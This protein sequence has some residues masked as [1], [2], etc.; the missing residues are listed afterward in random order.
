MLRK[1]I[2]FSSIRL[3]GCKPLGSDSLLK[4]SIRPVLAKAGIEG[5]QLG[6]HSFR[7]SLATNLRALGVDIKVAQELKRHASSRTMLDIYTRGVSQQEREA[8]EKVMDLMQTAG[9]EKLQH[10]RRSCRQNRGAASLCRERSCWWI[11]SGSTR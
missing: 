5:K 11:S 10:T 3:N 7:H 1:R 8:N 9:N 4:K 2:S 6:W